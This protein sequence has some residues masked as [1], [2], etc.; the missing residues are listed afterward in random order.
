MC[1]Y[2]EEGRKLKRSVIYEISK[3][4]DFLYSFKEDLMPNNEFNSERILTVI[5][6]L[7]QENSSEIS[8]IEPSDLLK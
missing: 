1:D 6:Q 3:E 2:C 8:E 5:N 7:I 4:N